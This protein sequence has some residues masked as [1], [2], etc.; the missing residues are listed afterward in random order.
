MRV[1]GI[2]HVE[3]SR[4]GAWVHAR[5]PLSGRQVSILVNSTESKGV[6]L[7]VFTT[8]NNSE[9]IGVKSISLPWPEFVALEDSEEGET[10]G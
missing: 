5:N 1:T 10:N 3:M 8:G 2:E 4:W 7:D 6:T 9:S